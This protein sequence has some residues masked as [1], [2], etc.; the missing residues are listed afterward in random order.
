MKNKFTND[1]KYLLKN[2]WD[3]FPGINES[4]L[5][6]N[7]SKTRYTL[8]SEKKTPSDWKIL[9]RCLTSSLY[10][11][12]GLLSCF[13]T[14]LNPQVW[15]RKIEEKRVRIELKQKHQEKISLSYD[16][17]N[18]FENAKNFE[19]SIG[20]YQKYD[21]SIKLEPVDFKQKERV[22]SQKNLEGVLK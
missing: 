3:I 14:S 11:T 1:L 20:I 19:D 6:K 15:D 5:I 10:I 18:I 2:S 8:F 21:L 7:V 4:Q 16:S 12:Y 22:V 17:F 9:G 13:Y